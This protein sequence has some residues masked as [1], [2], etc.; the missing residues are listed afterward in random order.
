MLSKVSVITVGSD[1]TT[2]AVHLAHPTTLIAH[3]EWLCLLNRYLINGGY[4]LS[5]G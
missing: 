3:T 4:L 2:V 5:V 1:V